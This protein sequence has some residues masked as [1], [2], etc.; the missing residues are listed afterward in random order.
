[1]KYL[2]NIFILTIEF[3]SQSK[4]DQH[5]KPG[6]TGRPFHSSVELLSNAIH[7]STYGTR[8]QTAEPSSNAINVKLF[9]D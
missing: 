3:T 1:M 6:I 5:W 9:V 4:L 8:T 2:N 7:D